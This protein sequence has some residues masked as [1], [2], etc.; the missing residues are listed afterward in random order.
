MLTPITKKSIKLLLDKSRI[1][2]IYDFRVSAWENSP[3]EKT[4]NKTLFPNGWYDKADDASLIWYLA[5]NRN[6]IIGTARLTYFHHIHE[7]K[8]IG[9]D[10]KKFNL[11]L[12]R[13]FALLSRLA[14]DK[15]IRGKGIS[16]LFDELRIEKLKT[17]KVKFAL[18]E[19][20]QE[21]VKSLKKF[22]FVP[23]GK[24]KF[25]PNLMGQEELLTLML[26]EVS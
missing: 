13:P 19:V 25:K 3:S 21:R 11:P 24:I 15:S 9:L 18:V 7:I 22:G 8:N 1:Q 14:I 2:E 23:I 26:L 12:E 4:V 16:S 5:D 17:D 10:I 20:I 6:K